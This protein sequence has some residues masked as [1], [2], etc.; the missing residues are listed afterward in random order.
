M[1]IFQG[2]GVAIITP[3]KKDGAV[4]FD[5]LGALIDWQIEQKSDAIVIVGT[6]GEASCLYDDEHLDTIG[7]AARKVAGRVPVIAGV[8]SNQTE[9][10][11]KLSRG[12]QKHGVDALLHVTP[13]YNKASRRG[14]IE[15]FTEIAD[16]V[17]IPILL[18]SVQG[19]T[20]MNLAPDVVAELAKHPNIVGLKEA[21]GNIAQVAEIA[22]VTPDDFDLYSGNDDMIV[23]L[24]SLGGKGVISVLANIMPRETHNMVM[25]FLAG[26]VRGA[27]KMQLDLKP[28]IDALFIEVNPI[29][30]KAALWLM[31]R[32]EYNYRLPL[33][34]MEEENLEKLKKELRVWN[35]L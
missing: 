30:V 20:G 23:P 14:L 27:C 10:G 29:P 17:D 11:I 16:S 35:L 5:R 7:Y 3:F 12:A 13:Y 19:R 26:D 18:Y 32:C 33:C 25:R 2:S 21:S 1:P 9:H 8:G 6:T 31:G 22:R 24:L 34:P 28:L 15:H 4:D